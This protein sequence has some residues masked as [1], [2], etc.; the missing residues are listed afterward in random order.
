MKSFTDLVNQRQSTR[1]Y[2]SAGVPREIIDQCIEASRLAPSASN[3]QPWKFI[4]VDDQKLVPQVAGNTW[5]P[6]IRFNKFT[7]NAPAFIVITLEPAKT[8]TKIGKTVKQKEWPLIDIGIAA[9]HFCLKA[10]DLGLGTCMLGWYN[11]KKIKKLLNIPKK[12]EIALLI[13][14]GY[15]PEDYPIREK[16]RKSFDEITTYN[17]YSIK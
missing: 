13:S 17:T 15:P 11:E 4:V 6:V 10:T 1:K 16:N 9:E 12:R 2:Q 7:E 3:S 8:I 14:I 5:D